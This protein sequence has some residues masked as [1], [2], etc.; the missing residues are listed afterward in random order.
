MM[1]DMPEVN[2]NES[3]LKS[4]ET[5][6]EYQAMTAMM[7]SLEREYEALEHEEVSGR[8]EIARLESRAKYLSLEIAVWKHRRR[9]FRDAIRVECGDRGLYELVTG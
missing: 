3:R 4:N 8:H 5:I 7:Q 1:D 6:R 2:E 9:G